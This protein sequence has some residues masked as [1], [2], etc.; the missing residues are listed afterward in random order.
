MNE[1]DG[2]FHMSGQ[3]GEPDYLFEQEELLKKSQ[4]REEEDELFL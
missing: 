1:I 4:V 2:L 3:Q